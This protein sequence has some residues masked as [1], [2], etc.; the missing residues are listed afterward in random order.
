MRR[1]ILIQII[2]GLLLVLPSCSKERVDSVDSGTEKEW[3]KTRTAKITFVSNLSG[4]NPY[5][6]DNYDI[7]GENIK[8]GDSHIVILDR[9]NVSYGIERTNPGA[10]IAVASG[11][12][13]IFVPISD[14]ETAYEGSSVLF[15]E[16]VSQ[17]ELTTVA[18]DCRMLP[19]TLTINQGLTVKITLLSFDSE[20]QINGSTKLF[21]SALTSSTL[22]VGT[23][24]RSH[25]SKLESMLE[26]S[27]EGAYSFEIVE[28]APNNSTY[29]IYLFGSGKW[30]LREFTESAVTGGIK[31]FL[32]QAEYL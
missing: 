26:S 11:L 28:N 12:F 17:M 20:N 21:R 9:A 1:S 29:A 5:N 10:K 31:Q 19:I 23:I 30:V 27:I 15:S 6:A 16:T 13:P 3:N 25:V 7:V 4:N 2:I 22:I 32:I 8:G 18:E 24:Q 14:T